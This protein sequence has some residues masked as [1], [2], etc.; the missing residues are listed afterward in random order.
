M[1]N[2][3]A[4]KIRVVATNVLTVLIA[5]QTAVTVIVT[6]LDDVPVVVEYGTVTVSGLAAAIAFI[7]RVSP[8]ESAEHGLI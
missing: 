2:Q 6:E 7:R 5:A 1:L 4:T 8:V 3:F